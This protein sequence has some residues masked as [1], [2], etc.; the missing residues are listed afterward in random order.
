MNVPVTMRGFLLK[1]LLYKLKE[2]VRFDE[3]EITT[4]ILPCLSFDHL[5]LKTVYFK[6]KSIS[7]I[8]TFLLW[9]YI[10]CTQSESNNH[11]LLKDFSQRIECILTSYSLTVLLINWSHCSICK[12]SSNEKGPMYNTLYLLLTTVG[13]NFFSY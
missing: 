6:I 10:S 9:K 7:N 12:F 2:D 1:N 13:L 4:W 11:N 8:Y 3:D 5:L